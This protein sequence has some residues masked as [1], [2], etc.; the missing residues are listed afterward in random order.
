MD[1]M[2]IKSHHVLRLEQALKIART[3]AVETINGVEYMKDARGALVPKSAIKAQDILIDEEVRKIF[4]FAQDISGQLARFK[5]HCF[6]D[7]NSLQ[8]LLEQNYKAKQG[9]KKGNVQFVSFD[10]LKKITIQ[11]ADQIYFGPELQVAKSII[12]ECLVEWG[13]QS[14]E[15]VRAL[16]NRVFSV[17]K[18]GQ[19]NRAELFSLMRLEIEDERWQ[20]AMEALKDSIRVQGT[21][22]YI[23]FHWRTNTNAQWSNVTLDIANAEVANETV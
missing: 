20:R 1:A 9:G 21:K 3:E 8:S 12:D 15:A 14:H 2:E 4:V 11:I 23:R 5:G 17:E 18:A 7:L 19:I 22:S 13:S 6:E 10:G 16:I